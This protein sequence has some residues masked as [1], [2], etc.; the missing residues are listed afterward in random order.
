MFFNEK[1]ALMEILKKMRITIISLFLFFTYHG[2]MV[3]Q[4]Q[5]HIESDAIVT[6]SFWDNW[7]GQVG[8]DM[9][10][11]FP[12]GHDMKNVFPNGKSFG[13]DVA[14]GKWFAPE[15]GGR[16]KV[17]WGNGILK[18]DH[19]TW[20]SPYGIPGENHRQGGYITF[21][22]DISFNLHNLFGEY[23]SNRKWNL[24]VAPRAGG[25]IDV[26]SGSGGHVL[27]AGII[28]TYRLNDNWRLYADIGYHFISS[29]NGVG[30]GTGHGSNGFADINI[31]VE[32][33]LSKNTRFF[34]V[35]NHT[36]NSDK[37]TVLNSFWDN[38]FAQAGLGMSLI[39][40]YGTNFANVFPN[41]KTL[42]I[43]LGLGKWFTPDVG[44]RG[45]LN[46][47]NGLFVNHHASYLDPREGSEADPDKHGFV[48]LYGD[49]FIN[50]HNI[51]SGYDDSRKWDAIVFPR[52]G[53]AECFSSE[54]KECP[55]IGLGTEHTYKIND[56]LKLFADVVYQVTTGGFL[57]IKFD[58]GSGAGSNG[59][60]DL[61]IGVQ[62]ELGKSKGKWK[63]AERLM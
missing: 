31:G 9:N 51:I 62:Y 21:I 4:V 47:Q 2:L 40:P 29:V 7:Y 59:W 45:G 58:T 34:R 33:D 57:D 41:G 17:N 55:V 39:N 37:T 24:I 35:A 49:V 22:G 26:G 28:N 20:L 48:V 30:S 8:V 32:M 42:G 60:F 27:G 61:N 56:R 52:M 46:W 11:L 54:Y 16:L 15:F 36:H 1:G 12:E 13:V 10:L 18:N 23:Q 53:I 38:W 3:A 19:N 50:L 25:W 63:R 5:N 44:V 6:N 43:N 14:V